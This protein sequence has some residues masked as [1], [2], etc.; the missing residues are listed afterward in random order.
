MEGINAAAGAAATIGCVGVVVNDLGH[1][2][3]TPPM[4]LLPPPMVLGPL[5]VDLAALGV[6]GVGVSF[7]GLAMP[8]LVARRGGS[9]VEGGGTKSRCRGQ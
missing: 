9:Q 5:A 6:A 1:L 4:V 3:V 2:L 8:T 7:A